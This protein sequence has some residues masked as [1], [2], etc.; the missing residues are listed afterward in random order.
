MSRL[1]GIDIFPSPIGVRLGGAQTY[2]TTFGGVMSI[3]AVLTLTLISSGTLLSY[4]LKGD[5]YNTNKAIEY[6]PYANDV[7]FEV[8]EMEAFVAFQFVNVSLD[9]RAQLKLSDIDKY[10][11][12]YFIQVQK[13]KKGHFK[14]VVPAVKCKHKYLSKDPSEQLQKQY[15]NELASMTDWLCPETDAFTILNKVETFEQA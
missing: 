10:L 14:F 11:N 1:S 3:V 8:G 15:E 6:L 5:Q 7:E 4:Y 12:Y 9:P 2:K 13:G